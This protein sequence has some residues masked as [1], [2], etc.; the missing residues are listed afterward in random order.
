MVARD[1]LLT[2]RRLIL[3]W[4]LGSG[5]R[6]AGRPGAAPIDLAIFS[7]FVSLGHGVKKRPALT[8]FLFA[9]THNHASGGAN[10]SCVSLNRDEFARNND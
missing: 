8:R 4:I 7:N 2:S 3:L 1:E 6:T 9:Q 5:A 10:Q